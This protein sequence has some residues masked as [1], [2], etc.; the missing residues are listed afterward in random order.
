[1][2]FFES[3]CSLVFQSKSFR[4]PIW[5]QMDQQKSG[6][7][8]VQNHPTPPTLRWHEKVTNR[9]MG[10][11]R[12]IFFW[13]FHGSP[14][15]RSFTE[16]QVQGVNKNSNTTDE[17]LAEK[18]SH[19]SKCPVHLSWTLI[20]FCFV[21]SIFLRT[22]EDFHGN[23]TKILCCYKISRSRHSAKQEPLPL[24]WFALRPPNLTPWPGFLQHFEDHRASH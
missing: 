19:L 13:S 16:L 24:Q 1:M 7:F 14:K 22:K 21:W 8:L 11:F 9:W 23:V 15:L 4:I 6:N 2:N 10:C 3:S 20:C 5:G 12:W 17:S 18:N